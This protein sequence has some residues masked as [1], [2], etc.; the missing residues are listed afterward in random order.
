MCPYYFFK[1]FIRPEKFA[2]RGQ[3]F[4][5]SF[6]RTLLGE[7]ERERDEESLLVSAH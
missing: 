4:K 7:R 5:E 3:K 2:R 1:R 6:R